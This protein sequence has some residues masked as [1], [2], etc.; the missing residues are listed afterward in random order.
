[1][2]DKNKR[3]KI[4]FTCG[5]FDLLHVGHIIM[6]EEARSVC[7]HLIVAIQSDPSTASKSARPDSGPND[8]H[9]DEV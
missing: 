7:D 9:K 4:G 1:M 8:S 5:A 3:N 6:L 2:S